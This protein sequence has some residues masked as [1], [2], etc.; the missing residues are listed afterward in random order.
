[1]Q[2]PEHRSTLHQPRP[3]VTKSLQCALG[4]QFFPGPPLR[5]VDQRHELRVLSFG[6]KLFA[7]PELPHPLVDGVV[8]PV[9]C[10]L[11]QCFDAQ[12]EGR[13]KTRFGVHHFCQFGPRHNCYPRL[14]SIMSRLRQGRE[15]T[16]AHYSTSVDN[17]VQLRD[18]RLATGRPGAKRGGAGAPLLAWVRWAAIGVPLFEVG[19]LQCKPLN[20]SRISRMSS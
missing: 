5:K 6:K 17:L 9:F 12:L 10:H 4:I 16:H 8:E 11:L 7:L 20:R 3:D 2:I 14:R 19:T 13:L 1:M 18:A 15:E